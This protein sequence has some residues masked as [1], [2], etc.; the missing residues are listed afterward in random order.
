MKSKNVDDPSYLMHE[1]INH[2]STIISIA[3][4][5]LI[6][7]EMSPEVQADMKRIIETVR[8]MSDNLKQ[9]AELLEEGDCK[10]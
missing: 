1:T 6:S 9:L 7:K 8:Q 10:Q 3:Q 2:I 5:S 4:L